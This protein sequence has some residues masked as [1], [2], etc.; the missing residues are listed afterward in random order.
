MVWF[1]R[2]HSILDR[3]PANHDWSGLGVRVLFWIN[4]QTKIV[5]MKTTQQRS[6]EKS[7]ADEKT[8]KRPFQLEKSFHQGK[9][10]GISIRVSVARS[11]IQ[12]HVHALYAYTDSPRSSDTWIY[13]GYQRIVSEPTDRG[14]SVKIQTGR[15]ASMRIQI[16]TYAHTH[17]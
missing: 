14:L 3:R 8:T 17:T 6:C 1:R 4:Q 12:K 9:K 13:R 15:H 5:R 11:D 7:R 10:E 2:P 16:H